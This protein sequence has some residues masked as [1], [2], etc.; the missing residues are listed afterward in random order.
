MIL[1]AFS[2]HDIQADVYSPPFFMRSVGE[3]TRAFKDLVNNPETTPGKHPTAFRL[4]VLGSFDDTAGSLI[5]EAITSLGVGSD[6]V[7]L[8]SNAVPLG[9]VKGA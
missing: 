8:P 2:I 5:A 1:R 4:V 3:A 7:D 9:I 6:Y